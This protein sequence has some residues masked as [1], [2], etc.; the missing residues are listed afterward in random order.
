MNLLLTNNIYGR[1][2]TYGGQLTYQ[3][4]ELLS[5][6]FNTQCINHCQWPS[7]RH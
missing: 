7:P 2:T 6:G 3:H 4:W 1:I 5:F